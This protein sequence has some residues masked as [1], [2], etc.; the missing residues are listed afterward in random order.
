MIYLHQ[1]KA[2]D[3]ITGKFKNDPQVYSLIISGSI[4]H[5]FNDEKSD[6]DI[7][8]II[9]DDLYEQKKSNHELTYWE[10]AANFYKEGY[11][12]GKYI[13]LDYLRI[14][15]KRGNEPTRFA[16]QDSIIAFDKTGE[17]ADCIDKIGTYDEN[18]VQK[19]NIRFLAQFEAWKWY[20][21]EALKRQNKYLLDTSVSK[22]IL[23][24]GRLIL[25]DNKIFFPYHKWF[26]KALENAPKKPPEL[27]NAI[28]RLMKRKSKKNID[29]LY[30]IIKK[31]KDWSNGINFSWS[32]YFLHDVETVWMR[33]EEFIENI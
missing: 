9:S 25:M 19:N 15:A 28:Y 20:C 31:Y 26:I 21:D 29:T 17:V 30:Q 12:D 1:Q 7:N 10:S 11:F 24:S 2:I 22:F 13:T 33:E 3:Y 32:A 18:S 23:F 14:V 4:A 16:L 5:G 6:I 8:I 27:M